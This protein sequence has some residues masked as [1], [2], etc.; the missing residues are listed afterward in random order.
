M[1]LRS[2]IPVIFPVVKIENKGLSVKELLIRFK[3][4][5]LFSSD[6]SFF[7]LGIVWFTFSTILIITIILTYGI[8]ANENYIGCM[9]ATCYK[10][11]IESY[12]LPIGILSLLIPFGAIYAA[13]H[14]SEISIAQ[15]KVTESQ[16]N[17]A[18]YYK[19]LEEFKHLLE[20]NNFLTE[21][22]NYRQLHL[23]IFPD[24]KSGNYKIPN[25]NRSKL[26]SEFLSVYGK[27]KELENLSRNVIK[28]DEA[29]S[30]KKEKILKEIVA[31]YEPIKRLRKQFEISLNDQDSIT[32]AGLK[33][34]I[35]KIQ[36]YNYIS[37]I[38]H[39]ASMFLEICKFSGEFKVPSIMVALSELNDNNDVIGGLPTNRPLSF[40]LPIISEDGERRR[41]TKIHTLVTDFESS[42]G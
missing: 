14:R 18:N 33:E 19:H 32:K 27:L 41:V 13:Q 15:I 34:Y 12:K 28:S 6:K 16:N 36:M 7:Q 30:V 4:Y 2:F 37:A 35:D 39:T 5:R 9:S 40:N 21:V 10:T 23:K 1:Y 38:S 26:V 11:F 42:E 24:V 31:A 17:I 8:T 22:T 25:S 20:D 3:N 29:G